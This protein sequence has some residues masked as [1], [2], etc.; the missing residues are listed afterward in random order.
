MTDQEYDKMLSTVFE[1]GEIDRMCLMA[2]FEAE[3]I[4]GQCSHC[5]GDK[6]SCNDVQYGPH[7]IHSVLDYYKK[8]GINN[9]TDE[10]VEESY[11]RTYVVLKRH[12]I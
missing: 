6:F 5:G 7:C 9:L 3:A 2:L 4:I 12:E 8:V 1:N 10:G 11:I